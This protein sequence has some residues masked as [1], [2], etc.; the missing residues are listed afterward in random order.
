MVPTEIGGKKVL[1]IDTPGFDDTK[2]SDSEILTTITEMLVAQYKLGVRLKG[3]IYLHRVSDER[4]SGSAIKTLTIFQKI[5]G[6]EALKNVILATTRWDKVDEDLGSARETQLRTEFWQYMISKG[7]FMT[8][9]YGD[10]DSALAIA[11]QLLGKSDIV[12]DIQHEVV[13]ESKLLHQTSAGTVVSDGLAL[14]KAKYE[15]ELRDLEELKQTLQED[16]RLLKKQL[17]RDSEKLE[18][19]KRKSEQDALEDQKRLA[20]NI[21]QDVEQKLSA[22]RRSKFFHG[23]G[24]ALRFAPALIDLIGMF[25]GIPP[26]CTTLLASWASSSGNRQYG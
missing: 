16:D 4:Y 13:D 8:R 9:F 11:S 14:V 23:A 20:A 18:K 15:Q 3:A 26:G 19:E 21:N 22:R 25:V 17:Q 24:V 7:S 2:R 6:P 1:L 12:L 10:G 5:C